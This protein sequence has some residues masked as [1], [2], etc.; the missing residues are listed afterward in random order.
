MGGRGSEGKTYNQ[1]DIN[2]IEE[3]PHERSAGRVVRCRNRSSRS[4][5]SARQLKRRVYR[6]Y[7]LKRHRGPSGGNGVALTQVS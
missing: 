6:E 5:N 7:R 4:S 2:K 1:E 3:A